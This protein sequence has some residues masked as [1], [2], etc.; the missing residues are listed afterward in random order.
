METS[1][2]ETGSS[3][4]INSGSRIEYK[5]KEID[6]DNAVTKTHPSRN[7]NVGDHFPIMVKPSGSC[8]L[9]YHYQERVA[10]RTCV[11]C[12][13]CDVNLCLIMTGIVSIG[14]TIITNHIR[15]DRQVHSREY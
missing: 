3:A 2:A 8:K 11:K 1:S 6:I 14:G 12:S 10:R 13:C 5:I 9:C 15:L 4:T 7:S